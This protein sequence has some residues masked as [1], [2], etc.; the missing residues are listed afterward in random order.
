MKKIILTDCDGVLLY[1]VGGFDKFMASKGHAMKSNGMSHYD[2][3]DR[4]ENVTDKVGNDFV[5]EFNHSASIADLPP[6]MDAPI[7]V[8]KL[9]DFG[10]SFIA[11]TSLSDKKE[12]K[13]YRIQNLRSIYGDVF[14]DVVCLAQGSN[15]FETLLSW[16]DTGYFWI[17]DH[18]KQAEA[19]YLAGLSPILI[20]HPYNKHYDNKNFPTVGPDNPWK[21]IYH[22]VAKEYNLP[23]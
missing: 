14:D 8:K 13:N 20:E 11:V 10:F 21:E 17:E 16:Q 22:I 19:G 12:A 9:A 23:I 7:Y 15:K 3:S 5:R 6:Y 1:W 2:I 4:Y 18:E